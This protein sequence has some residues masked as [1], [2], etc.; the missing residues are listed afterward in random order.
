MRSKLPGVNAA[1]TCAASA[2]AATSWGSRRLRAGRAG[3]G[4]GGSATVASSGVSVPRTRRLAA[5]PSCDLRHRP[6]DG[7]GGGDG[8]ASSSSM[9]TTS[10]SSS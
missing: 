6:V 9:T 2:A 10:S 4:V 3:D 5:R 8:A 7:G 1:F